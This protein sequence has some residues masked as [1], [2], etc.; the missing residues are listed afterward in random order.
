MIGGMANIGTT[1][2]NN[3]VN[4]LS[5][6]VGAAAVQN[7]NKITNN[8][9]DIKHCGNCVLLLSRGLSTAFCKLHPLPKIR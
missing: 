6:I 4:K 3:N 2:N 5:N 1:M 8:N 9:K 7:N